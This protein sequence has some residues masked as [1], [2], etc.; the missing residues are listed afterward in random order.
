MTGEIVTAIAQ[1][2]G[3]F[4]IGWLARRMRYLD[5][6]DVNRWSRLVIDFLMPLLAFH[7]ITAN[8]DRGRVR[9]LWAL[10]LI[11]FGMI[12]FG[13]LCGVL[14]RRALRSRDPD[15]RKT[16]HHFCAINNYGFLP[17][18]IVQSLWGSEGVA[19]LFVLNLGST[20]GYWTIGVGLLGGASPRQAAKNILG[21]NLAAVVFALALCLAGLNR[22][23]PDL[24]LRIAST[25][26]SAAVPSILL[27]IGA[28]LYP[29]PSIRHKRDLAYLTAVRLVL[30]PAGMV[31]AL[32]ALPIPEAARNVA[33]IVALMPGTV[34][35]T[36]ITR[37][38]GGCPDFAARAAIVTTL[39][40]MG[41]IPLALM[42]LK[43]VL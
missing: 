7:S 4:A 34:S 24:V 29:L 21:P 30:L 8:F 28:T 10:P 41:T 20:V 22:Y 18:I 42:L 16:F 26:G 15:I 33:L 35:S 27:L 32:L 12:A 6:S 19:R 38:F 3:V 5:E 40:S 9:E 36:I 31:A 13:A 43:G 11:G 23:V 1:I 17:I 25:A 39:I 14:L 2:F 37:R